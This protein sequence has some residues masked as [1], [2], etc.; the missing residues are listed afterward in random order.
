M[1]T[2]LQ[3]ED[4]SA[5]ADLIVNQGPT[6]AKKGEGVSQGEI[7]GATPLAPRSRLLLYSPWAPLRDDRLSRNQPIPP[8]RSGVGSLFRPRAAVRV[9][10]EAT[11]GRWSSP[12]TRRT[13]TSPGGPASLC[14]AGSRL[15]AEC[16]GCAGEHASGE[17]IRVLLV[18]PRTGYTFRPL[19]AWS[20]FGAAEGQ[21]ARQE[22]LGT[23]RRVPRR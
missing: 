11:S 12:R 6:K 1:K 15:P 14:P 10:R 4:K 7:L 22:H 5:L 20:G 3:E 18:V 23:P 2:L 19:R 8:P 21:R 17:A 13:R 9:L 16:W